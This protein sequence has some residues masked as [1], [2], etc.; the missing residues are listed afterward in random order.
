MKKIVLILAALLI[1]CSASAQIVPTNGDGPKTEMKYK[2]L[3]KIYDHKDYTREQDQSYRPTGVAVASFFI[4]GLGEMI[5]GEG[6]R[7]TAFL[8]TWLAGHFVALVGIAELSD[9][10]YYTGVIGALATRVVSTIDASR[11]AKVKNMYNRDLKEK[12]ALDVSLYPSISY[13]KTAEGVQPTTGLTL[14]IS[15]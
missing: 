13:I 6:W 15:F 1:G 3:K 12:N 7:G 4:P 8:G 2:D 10:I 9:N 5:C 11:I 14:S